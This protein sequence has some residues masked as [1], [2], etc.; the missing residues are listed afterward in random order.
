MNKS[1]IRKIAFEIIYSLETQNCKYEDYKENIEMFFE[2]RDIH[3]RATTK[4]IKDVVYGT[5]RHGKQ[6]KK[7]IEGCLSEK[8]PYDRIAKVNI[9]ILELAIFE[10]LFLKTPYKVVINEAVELAKKS[11]ANALINTELTVKA[12][13]FSGKHLFCYK[14]NAAII[15]GAEYH[16]QP[17]IKLD[18][19]EK[20]VRRNSPNEAMIRY[21]RVLLISVLLIILPCLLSLQQQGTLP[22]P[23]GSI[24][25][26]IALGLSLFT[27]LFY[28]SRKQVAYLLRQKRW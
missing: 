5:K 15:E 7:Q 28:S 10:M 17:G 11:N 24:A 14:A 6:I 16:Q 12:L 26:G 22:T 2:D 23:L 9:A 1:E 21:I 13:R 8:W 20:I 27:G 25:C 3:G 4:Y 18:I 19:N